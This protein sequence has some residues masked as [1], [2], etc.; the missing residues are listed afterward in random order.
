MHIQ[1]TSFMHIQLTSFMHRQM[2]SFMHRQMRF[3][4]RQSAS[5]LSRG[6][7]SSVDFPEWLKTMPLVELAMQ[8]RIPPL[9][10][11]PRVNPFLS[12]VTL[13]IY[14]AL[15]L[16][17]TG[18]DILLQGSGLLMTMSRPDLV[19]KVVVAHLAG[20]RQGTASSKSRG[21]VRGG[22]RKLYAQKKTGR[23]RAGSSRAPHRRGGGACHGP[24]PRDY[25]LRLNG[26]EVWL[27]A[28]SVL[29]D[30]HRSGLLFPFDRQSIPGD[31]FKTQSLAKTTL[32]RDAKLSAL[33]VDAKARLLPDGFVRA[34][35]RL[36]HVLCLD[37]VSTARFVYEAVRHNRLLV[38]SEHLQWLS[39]LPV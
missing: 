1:L 30:K 39:Q 35:R 29:A 19:H 8:R 21:E 25:S 27:A 16:Q 24:R 26:K 34:S 6:L 38:A 3:A 5:V 23:A 7:S 32:F 37:E 17:P 2:T 28:R 14:D 9:A 36:S 13:P 15:S 11:I 10:S 22:G 31:V 4:A 33:L 20:L 12:T 18:R